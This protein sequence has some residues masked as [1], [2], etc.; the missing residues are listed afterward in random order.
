MNEYQ[1]HTQARG[2]YRIQ[3]HK[4]RENAVAMQNT[5]QTV[6]PGVNKLQ[7]YY[8]EGELKFLREA[9]A[10]GR[11]R[12][13][14]FTDPGVDYCYRCPLSRKLINWETLRQ[15]IKGHSLG[16]ITRSQ[17]PS[18]RLQSTLKSKQFS[19]SKLVLRGKGETE[20]SHQI[21]RTSRNAVQK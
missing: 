12:Q 7:E 8:L 19:A 16:C 17:Q 6:H 11:T 1:T 15:N 10:K 3:D 14:H 4:Q 5:K 2:S 9:V 18:T 13:T 20:H 21:T